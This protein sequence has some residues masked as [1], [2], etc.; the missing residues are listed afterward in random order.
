MGSSR[1]NKSEFLSNKVAGLYNSKAFVAAF[2]LGKDPFN[3]A[4][5]PNGAHALFGFLAGVNLEQM[6]SQ[7]VFIPTLNL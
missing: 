2:T 6:P 7:L 5:A 4:L 3:K 1:K